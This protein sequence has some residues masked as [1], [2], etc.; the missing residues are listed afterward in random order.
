MLDHEHPQKT[1]RHHY[2]YWFTQKH[3]GGHGD[4]QWLETLSEDDEFSVFDGAD[5]MEIADQ[6]KNLYGA[7]PEG[8]NSLRLL[9]I[10][11]EQI[12]KFWGPQNEQEPWHGFPVWSINQEGPGNRR[13]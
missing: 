7:L 4:G 13:K 5:E 3:H 9:G 11:Q 12:A 8:E 10:Y 2:R 1:R 6:D